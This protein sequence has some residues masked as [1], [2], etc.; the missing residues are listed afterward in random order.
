M[1]VLNRDSETPPP[2]APLEGHWAASIISPT[3]PRSVLGS[4]PRWTCS[5]HSSVLLRN[6][7]AAQMSEFSTSTW[8]QL[9]F[10]KLCGKSFKTTHAHMTLSVHISQIMHIFCGWAKNIFI[11]FQFSFNYLALNHHK[12]HI[13]TFVHTSSFFLLWKWSVIIQ[14]WMH[15]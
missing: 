3:C 5:I 10:V 1:L 12:D 9:T 11:S 4:A 2:L 6:M 7:Q 8:K 13:R 14:V 15:L